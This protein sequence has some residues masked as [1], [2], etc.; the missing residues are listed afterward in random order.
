VCLPLRF[1]ARASLLAAACC[2]LAPAVAPAQGIAAKAT[3]QVAYPSAQGGPI[4]LYCPFPT[5]YCPFPTGYCPPPQ[6]CCDWL[7]AA[8]QNFRMPAP[9]QYPSYQGMGQ[10][11]CCGQAAPPVH[12]APQAPMVR[13]WPQA[14]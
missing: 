7:V 9:P 11:G 5:G 14:R 10:A 12:V 6:G 8:A 4:S 1:L 3:P 2:V 13:P